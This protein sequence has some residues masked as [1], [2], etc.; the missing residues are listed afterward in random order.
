MCLWSQR[1]N[2]LFQEN[3]RRVNLSQTSISESSPWLNIPGRSL[4][5]LFWQTFS[6]SL[7]S[8]WDYAE[9][10]VRAGWGYFERSF[11]S[12][13][14]FSENLQNFIR[15]RCQLFLDIAFR[16]TSQRLIWVLKPFH[17]EMFFY[18]KNPEPQCARETLYMY[19]SL[20]WI[21]DP[22]QLVKK[23]YFSISSVK[24]QGINAAAKK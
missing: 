19:H 18:Y 7:I 5:G 15:E 24:K 6:S 20:I 12:C 9:D 1:K 13:L 14:G 16:F 23:H 8:A 11:L 2:K 10:P 17:F 21:G 22:G 3:Q 4:C